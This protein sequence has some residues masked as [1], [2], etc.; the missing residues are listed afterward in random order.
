MLQNSLRVGVSHTALDTS[1]AIYASIVRYDIDS[2]IYDQ[3]S[4]GTNR[5]NLAH[6]NTPPSSPQ[7]YLVGGYKELLS[8]HPSMRR[9]G[10][11]P[12]ENK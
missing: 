6:D 11:L 8:A 4:W 7:N 9:E 2:S 10:E 12:V 3:F 5:N 1:Q